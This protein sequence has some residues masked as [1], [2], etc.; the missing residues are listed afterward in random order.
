M[1]NKHLL[2]G[3]LIFTTTVAAGYLVKRRVGAVR[4]VLAEEESRE[5]SNE[6]YREREQIKTKED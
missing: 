3:V 4:Q 1:K 6:Y 5:K 2:I